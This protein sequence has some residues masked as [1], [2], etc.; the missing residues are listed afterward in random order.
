MDSV[1]KADKLNQRIDIVICEIDMCNQMHNGKNEHT[2]EVFQNPKIDR[3]GESR[4]NLGSG[5]LPLIALYR[6]SFVK[7]YSWTI[8]DQMPMSVLEYKGLPVVP[9][10][11]RE[12]GSQLRQCNIYPFGFMFWFIR[13]RF[14]G[15]YLVFRA[16]RR[17]YLAGG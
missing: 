13:N 16:T 3:F 8:R 2:P 1:R 5:K 4:R 17:S 11:Q 10:L 14:V 7:T 15:S 6:L 9:I 12:S